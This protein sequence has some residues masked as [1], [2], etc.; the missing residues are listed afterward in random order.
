MKKFNLQLFAEGGAA[1]SAGSASASTTQAA[2]SNQNP[3]GEGVTA[4]AEGTTA[5]QE[6]TF[7]SLIK[8]KY[9]KEYND[10]IQNAIKARFKENSVHE[11]TL[12]KIKPALEALS[13]HYGMEELDYEALSKRIMDDPK[14]YEAEALAR[15]VDVNEIKRIKSVERELAA[16]RS[17]REKAY[18][19]NQR[20]QQFEAI[21]QQVPDVQ[22]IYPNFDLR[23]EMQ[24]ENFFRLVNAKVPVQ[25][26]YEVIHRDEIQPAVMQM[27]AQKTQEQ[28][29]NQVMANQNR[30]NESTAGITGATPTVDI[31]KLSRKEFREYQKRAARGEKI[32]FK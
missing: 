3:T 31:S 9:K 7:E 21:A 12:N 14:L 27:V 11:T 6:E 10:S 22:K 30:P 25:V 29:A 19:E 5:Q 8:G 24:D 28:L 17:E 15:G 4:N 13:T 23:A 2:G 26:A 20:R 18:Q 32:T 16:L 1:A